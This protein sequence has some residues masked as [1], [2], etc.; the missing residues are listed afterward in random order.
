MIHRLAGLIH[1][2]IGPGLCARWPSG[3]RGARSRALVHFLD[4]SAWHSTLIQVSSP[5]KKLLVAELEYLF[6]VES[7]LIPSVPDKTQEFL[8]EP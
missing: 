2:Y 7:L 5:D 6:Q 8:C 1:D 3:P 4:G